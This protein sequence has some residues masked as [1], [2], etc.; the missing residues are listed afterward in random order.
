[1]NQTTTRHLTLCTA[2]G[3]M[4]GAAQTVHAHAGFKD[5][6]T[7]GSVN[8]WNA[9]TITHGCNTNVGGENN[10]KPHKDV[11]AVSAIFPNS[12]SFDDVI[13]RKSTG[14]V[15]A[16]TGACIGYTAQENPECADVGVGNETAMDD[17]SND[18]VGANTKASGNAPI[19][20]SISAV[21]VGNIFANTIPIADGNGNLRG[22]QSWAG[23]KPFNGPYLL[24]SAKKADGSDI[25][26]TGL[27]PFRI[28]K[29]QFQPNS[30]VTKLIVR[31]AAADWCGKGGKSYKAPADN[32]DVWVG[33]K[34]E[35]FNDQ[36]TMPNAAATGSDRGAIN[37][38]TLTI[39][40]DLANN[41]LPDTCTANDYDTV[42]IEP[43]QTDID[44]YLPISKAK[45]P[46]GAGTKYWPAE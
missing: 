1:M 41:P 7:E 14:S 42:Y 30:C 44:K 33:S 40:R 5:Q 21:T 43:T 26:T 11:I 4:L 18:I 37:W 35:K 34:T 16:Q 39:N 27:A 31:V 32:V 19:P 28:S 6:I 22:F 9:V 10:G 20:M 45:Y 23:P 12:P 24:E 3:L 38:P 36:D 29:F 17:L 46:A 15:A 25:N 8:T 13:I 2:M